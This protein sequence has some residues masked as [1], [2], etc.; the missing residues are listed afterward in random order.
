MSAT[1]DQAALVEPDTFT[2]VEAKWWTTNLGG[3]VVFALVAARSRSRLVR[4]VF[5]LAVLT[6]AVE[7]LYSYDRARR[8]GFHSS[9]GRWALQ[10]LA[11]GFPSVRALHGAIADT[12]TRAGDHGGG[13]SEPAPATS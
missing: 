12:A 10:S 6:H 3:M 8:A 2:P 5:K 11:V 13:V 7:A 9:A 1:L 4:A